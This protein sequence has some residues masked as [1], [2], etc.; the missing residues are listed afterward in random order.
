MKI[1]E[2]LIN[3]IEALPYLETLHYGL[4]LKHRGE[5]DI[6]FV[7]LQNAC[8]LGGKNMT[9]MMNIQFVWQDSFMVQVYFNIVVIKGVII[10]QQLPFIL[11]ICFKMERD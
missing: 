4:N 9:L 7:L 10:T 8:L 1:D 11:Q 5:M 3:F 2:S 6:V